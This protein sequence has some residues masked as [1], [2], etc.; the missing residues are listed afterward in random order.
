M[1]TSTTAQ[2]TKPALT[3]GVASNRADQW[4]QLNALARAWAAGGTKGAAKQEECT[5]QWHAV[6]ALEHFWAYPGPRLLEALSAALEAGDAATFARLVQ[7]VSGALLS[8]GFRRSEQAW[9]ADADGEGWSL[10]ALPPDISGHA[11]TK[12]YFEVLVVTPTAPSEWAQAREE[13]G[14][15]RRD[16]DAFVYAIVS[17][18]SFEDA[19]MA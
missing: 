3:F 16:D 17:A 8:G 15:M 2:T 12:P 14:K 18:G 6:R 7:K 9:L 4:R 1:N 19:A 13:I 11:A 5:R 10:D